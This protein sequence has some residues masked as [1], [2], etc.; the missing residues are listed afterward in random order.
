YDE[1]N[2]IAVNGVVLGYG[3]YAYPGHYTVDVNVTL[4]AGDELVIAFRNLVP[5]HQNGRVAVTST[6]QTCLP[7][8]SD[9]DGIPN[10]LD[11]DS[12]N[13]GIPDNI[14]AQSTAN[15]VVPNNDTLGD[16]TTNSG[17]NTAYIAANYTQ[18]G[19]TPNNNDGI[20]EPDYLDLDSDNTETDDTTEA[21]LTLSGIDTNFDGMDDN[22]LPVA[23]NTGIWQSG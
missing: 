14:E 20:D 22:I 18:D 1:D 17:L 9:N 10:H 19:I 3:G 23:I 6:V 5:Q 4:K 7:L 21:G 11:L 12:D 16:Y 15:Y 13:D 2:G 8:D